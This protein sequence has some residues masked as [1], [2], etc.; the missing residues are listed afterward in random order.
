MEIRRA[1]HEDYDGILHLLTQIA[2]LHHRGRPDIFKSG[3]KK[4]TADELSEITADPLKPVFVAAEDGQV[5]GYAFAVVVSYK[6]HAVFRDY[7]ALYIDDLCVDE[8]IR[9]KG[10]GKLLFEAITDFANELG[11]DMLDLN[12]WEFNKE[13]IAFYERMGMSTSRRRMELKLK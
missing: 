13:A 4:Y 5:L 7:T 11:I 9:G 10:V 3:V 12:V 6:N 1:R 8:N 2:A